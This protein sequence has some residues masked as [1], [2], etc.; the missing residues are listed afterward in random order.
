MT[1]TASEDAPR[2]RRRNRTPTNLQ[3]II[4]RT[5]LDQDLAALAHAQKGSELRKAAVEI[6][7]KA[8]DDGR[9]KARSA[10]E[11]GGDGM[12]CAQAISHLE[13]E[14][15]R[16]IHHFVTEFLYPAENRSAGERLAIAAVGGY[17]RGTLAP[18]SDID[19]LFLL[20]YKQTA[21]GESVVEAILYILWDL[22]QKVGHSTR[23]V[24]ECLRQ[25]VCL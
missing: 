2:S 22:R 1:M 4:D 21:W 17:G 13:D 9:A 16:S 18:G 12:A 3:E 11:A 15:I 10:L 8:L 7:R 19:L 14:I 5:K 24:D 23:S 6:F 25:A 20:P